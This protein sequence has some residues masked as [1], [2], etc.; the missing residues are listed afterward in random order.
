MHVSLTGP[1]L[2]HHR[3]VGNVPLDL[4]SP[5]LNT[6]GSSFPISAAC[7]IVKIVSSMINS[8]SIFIS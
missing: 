4:S 6:L 2:G 3:D 1:H 8:I 7:L 5:T